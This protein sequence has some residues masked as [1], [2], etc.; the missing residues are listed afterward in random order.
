MSQADAI[1]ALGQMADGAATARRRTEAG[2]V[3]RPWWSPTAR[4]LRSESLA[5]RHDEDA[6]VRGVGLVRGADSGSEAA[7]AA[8]LVLA[9]LVLGERGQTGGPHTDAERECAARS[10]ARVLKTIVENWD[11]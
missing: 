5:H 4:R 2:L 7:A 11:S 9:R 8:G 3:G 10:W 6:A 1:R